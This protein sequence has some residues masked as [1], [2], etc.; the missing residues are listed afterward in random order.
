LKLESIFHV[1][2][3]VVDDLVEELH[4]L[5]STD[6]EKRFALLINLLNQEGG[7]IVCIIEILLNGK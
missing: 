6:W 2:F 7:L 4:Y 1:P 5:L 3:T